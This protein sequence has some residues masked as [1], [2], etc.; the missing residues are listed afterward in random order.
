MV[1]TEKESRDRNICSFLFLQ[2]PFQTRSRRTCPNILNKLLAEGQGRLA[3]A[4]LNDLLLV[5]HSPEWTQRDKS[6]NMNHGDVSLGSKSPVW[7]EKSRRYSEDMQAL[8]V[9][10]SGA[11]QL[12]KKGASVGQWRK[13]RDEKWE[14]V[15]TI[16]WKIP[17]CKSMSHHLKNH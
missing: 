8:W 7:W 1:R 4:F 12:R 2:L 17:E 3:V 15:P 5:L 14:K 10:G 6:N 16:V 11:F 9:H 13:Y